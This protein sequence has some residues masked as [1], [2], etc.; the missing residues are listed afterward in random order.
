M[1]ICLLICLDHPVR[2]VEQCSWVLG[3]FLG[4][5]PFLQSPFKKK[6]RRII[7]KFLHFSTWWIENDFLCCFAIQNF[8]LI[9]WR[10][11][12][13]HRRRDRFPDVHWSFSF[14]EGHPVTPTQAVTSSFVNISVSIQKYVF[15]TGAEF[16]AKQLCCSITKKF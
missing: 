6:R 3:W 11:L 15:W 16:R 4:S 10:L 8:F 5:K 14:F 9:S 12:V 2:S 7:L 1:F 13:G